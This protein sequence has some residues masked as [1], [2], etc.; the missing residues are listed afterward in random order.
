MSFSDLPLDLS[1]K[2]RNNFNSQETLK[3]VHIDFLRKILLP[4][5]VDKVQSQKSNKSLLFCDICN[6]VF[7]RPSLLKRHFRTHTGNGLISAN[8]IKLC[9]KKKF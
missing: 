4:F 8:K 9:F 1:V 6:K 3:S 5:T 2:N 7:D